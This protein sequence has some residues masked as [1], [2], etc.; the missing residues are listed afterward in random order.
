MSCTPAKFDRPSPQWSSL[1]ITVSGGFIA[2]LGLAVMA[3]AYYAELFRTLVPEQYSTVLGLLV[4]GGGLLSIAFGSWR[5]TVLCASIALL[6]GL[7]ILSEFAL[8]IRPL[9]EWLVEKH[10]IAPAYKQTGISP[11]SGICLVFAGIG[12]MLMRKSRRLMSHQPV[13][14]LLGSICCTLGVIGLL[15]HLSKFRAAY[16]WSHL[17]RIAVL[18]TAAFAVAGTAR[19]VTGWQQAKNRASGAPHWLSILV[20]FGSLAATLCLWQALVVDGRIHEQRSVQLATTTVKS[21]IK[22]SIDF[23]VLRL[24]Q[25]AR[26]MEFRNAVSVPEPEVEQLFQASR[27]QS[28]DAVGLVDPSLNVRWLKLRSEDA[29]RRTMQ[30]MLREAASRKTPE[31]G[32]LPAA[33]LLTWAGGGKNF[34]AA[35]SSIR[36]RGVDRSVVGVF[37]ARR[38]IDGIVSEALPQGY[39]LSIR[40]GADEI[41]LRATADRQ[42]EEEWGQEVGIDLYGLRWH[43]RSW[44]TSGQLAEHISSIPE[45]ALV[46]GLLMAALL[47]L[48]IQLARNARRRADEVLV[49]NQKLEEEI[50]E[51][52][53]AESALAERERSLAAAN[54]ELE[55]FSYSV[56]H[57]LRAPL[58]SIDGFSQALIEDCGDHI[59]ETG[60]DYLRRIRAAAQRMGELIDSLLH[61]SRLTRSEIQVE[62]VDLSNLA[63]AVISEL[64]QLEPGREVDFVCAEH[65]IATGDPR[66]L[67]AVLENLISNAWKFTGKTG[68]ATIEFGMNGNGRGPTYFVKDNGAGFDMAYAG[69]L[70]G[71]FQRLHRP[72]DFPGCGIGLATVQRIIHRHNGHIW[73]E[74]SVNKGAGFY[75]T[76]GQVSSHAKEDDPSGGRQ[77]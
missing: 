18:L 27:L 24:L 21:E 50:V 57:D 44:P 75:F 69:K 14:A 59:D 30:D 3:A 32:V 1:V 4:F 40:D 77:S 46:V 17:T 12:L 11:V 10:P 66:L 6:T 38:L 76:L 8:G 48:Q 39:Q 49:I 22:A 72:A 60:Q 36:T 74:S 45:Q 25:F 31:L 71:A 61:L 42:N 35:V 67:R 23:Q 52:K 51:R 53:R 63:K 15:A 43:V 19:I 16:D 70:F 68:Q 5:M 20:G 58:R 62:R 65:A 26:A 41:C 54:K 34:L 2:T 13:L 9:I 33:P 37:D 7:L 73:A 47:V 56:S 55:A 64:R 29:S 28:L